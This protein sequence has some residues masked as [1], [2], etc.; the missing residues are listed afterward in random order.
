MKKSR[1]E[2]FISKLTDTELA[3]FIAYQYDGFIGSSKQKLKDAVLK[4]GL[5][6]E[7]LSE[8][9]NKG[10]SKPEDNSLHFCPRCY[11]IK[12]YV[13]TDHELETVKYY[14]Y[15]VAVDTLRCRLC[16][17]NPNKQKTKNLFDAIRIKFKGNKNVRIPKQDDRVFKEL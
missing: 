13:E 8:L 11:S 5:T 6:S 7:K 4:R 2:D 3:I 14:S 12:L 1:L 17:Y 10:L 15:E 9:F 16:G